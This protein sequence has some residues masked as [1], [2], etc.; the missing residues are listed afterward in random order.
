MNVMLLAAGLGTRLRPYTLHTPKPAIPWL[1]IP[2]GYYSLGFL[3]DIKIDKLVV[4]IHHLPK[5]IEDLYVNLGY[6]VEF[7]DET[8]KILGSGGGLRKALPKFI[9]KGSF[10][11]SNADE[12]MF[13]ENPYI[14]KEVLRFHEW[15]KGMATLL[16]M[17]H[18]EVGHKFGGL[19]GQFKS[20]TEFQIHKF[21]KTAVDG[22]QG[23]HF[24]GIMVLRDE[25]ARYFLKDPMSEENIL[26]ETLT[27]ALQEG[28]QVYAY[29]CPELHWFE[30]GNP[31]DFLAA[32]LTCA[33][34]ILNSEPWTHGLISSLNLFQSKTVDKPVLTQVKLEDKE[35][36]RLALKKIFPS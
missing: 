19:W 34:G 20:S 23:L 36:V 26:Y 15:H 8:D 14:M 24:T 30:T 3:E 5:Q 4:N 25:I 7:S 2:L 1:S 32:E 29:S 27:R 18:P 13:S 16:A 35:T 12:I 9:G 17:P 22:M 33:R 10:L 28:E 11:V 21:S 31:H 6:P